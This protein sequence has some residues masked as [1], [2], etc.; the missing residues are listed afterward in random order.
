M[1]YFSLVLSL[2][3]SASGFSAQ[4][5]KIST[6]KNSDLEQAAKMFETELNRPIKFVLGDC[7]GILRLKVSKKPEELELN[8][9]KQLGTM[10]GG[11]YHSDGEKVSAFTGSN[12]DLSKELITISGYRD[13]Q[14]EDESKA[15]EAFILNFSNSL[16]SSKDILNFSANHSNEDGTWGLTLIYDTVNQEVLFLKAGFCGT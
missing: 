11:L 15:S 1:K 14:D 12:F 4:F 2:L 7:S 5:T 8:S 13:Y 3:F 9:M 10:K 6:M 16:K